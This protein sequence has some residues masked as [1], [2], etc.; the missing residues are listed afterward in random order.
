MVRVV[1]V[2]VGHSNSSSHGGSGIVELFELVAN[3]GTI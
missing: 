3:G 1:V 2:E